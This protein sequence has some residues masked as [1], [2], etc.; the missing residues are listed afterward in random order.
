[1]ENIISMIG[2]AVTVAQSFVAIRQDKI[3]TFLI[4][5][6]IMVGLMFGWLLFERW[7]DNRRVADIANSITMLLSNKPMTLEQIASRLNENRKEPVT[8]A[9]L[10]AAL[11]IERTKGYIPSANVAATGTEGSNYTLRAYNSSN[12]PLPY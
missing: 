1:M 4:A 2:F 10:D 11:E 5:A 12:F 9:D 3:K 7:M 6:P 8:S